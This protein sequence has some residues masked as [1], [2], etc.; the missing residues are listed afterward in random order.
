[1]SKE[2]SLC[3]LFFFAYQVPPVIVF[4]RAFEAFLAPLPLLEEDI[5]ENI[6]N[7]SFDRVIGVEVRCME[8]IVLDNLMVQSVQNCNLVMNVALILLSKVSPY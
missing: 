4:Q 2:G 1:M 7:N 5:L 3:G 6:F 8:P